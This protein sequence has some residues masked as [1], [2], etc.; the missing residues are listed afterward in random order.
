MSER[1]I[2]IMAGSVVGLAA[3]AAAFEF[4]PYRLSI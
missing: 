3:R 2:A 1:M 4:I